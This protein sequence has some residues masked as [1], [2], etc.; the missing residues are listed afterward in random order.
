MHGPEGLCPQHIVDLLG[1]NDSGPALL[2]AITAF[3]NMFFRGHCPSQ[4][5]PV[6]FGT[7]LTAVIKKSGGIHL[8]AVGYYWC[9]LYAKCANYFASNKLATYFEPIQLGFGVSSGC[10]AAFLAYRRYL[11][12]MPDDHVI[13]KLDFTNA[14]NCLHRDVMLEAILRH[15]PEIYAF[16]HL[17]YSN[18]A[19]F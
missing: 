19:L 3:I 6:L 18:S 5:V 1:C 4:I 9:R 12:A 10:E 14:F 13:A 7:N 11:E 16:G 2:S 17:S 8:I 15:V